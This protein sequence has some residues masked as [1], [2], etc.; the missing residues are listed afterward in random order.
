MYDSHSKGDVVAIADIFWMCY[1]I[2]LTIGITTSGSLTCNAA[3]YT[4][5]VVHKVIH[6]AWDPVVIQR[7]SEDSFMSRHKCKKKTFF[8]WQSPHSNFWCENPYL[9]AI[10]S[11][12]IGLC[13]LLWVWILFDIT[14]LVTIENLFELQDAECKHNLSSFLDSAGYFFEE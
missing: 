12:L 2:G 3:K 6:K 7:V 11:P 13:C 9:H 8:S 5:R 14:F 10:S 1:Y 4:G